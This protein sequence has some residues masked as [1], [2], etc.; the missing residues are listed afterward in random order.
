MEDKIS[1]IKRLSEKIVNRLGGRVIA[2]LSASMLLALLSV[3]FTDAWVVSIEQQGR[4]IDQIEKNVVALEQLRSSLISA[5]SAQRGFLLSRRDDFSEAFTHAVDDARRN[6]KKIEGL[7]TSKTLVMEGKQEQSWLIALNSSLEAKAAEMRLSLSFFKSGKEDEAR[8]LVNLDQGILDMAKFMQYTQLLLDQQNEALVTLIAKRRTTTAVTRAAIIGSAVIL[9]LLVIMVI[10]QLV[11]EM[12]NR[13]LLRQQ[14]IRDCDVYEERLQSS[15]RMLKTMALD[16][17]AD[18]ERDRQKL[19]RELHDELG[20]ILTATKMDISWTMRKLK[21]TDPDI[22]EKLGK[23]MRYLD[24]GIQFKRQVV[25]NLH[26]SMITTFGF[27][28][29]LRSLIDDMGERNQWEMD[30]ILP[31]DTTE[32]NEPVNLIAYR[33][34]QETLNNASK[35]AQATKVS[36][37]MVVALD[38]LKLEI[39]DNGV[40]MTMDIEQETTHGL[41]GMRNRIMA[42]GGRIEL[43]SQPGKGVHLLAIVPMQVDVA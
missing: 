11:H 14:L 39:E 1:W 35:Y 8:H 16:Y 12:T 32:L 22:T 6:I 19:A 26:P 42:I 40:G 10:R 7:V 4:Q 30:V 27:W 24:Q 21:T 5:E 3:V 18:V 20:S 31:D 15:T 29:A 2:V 38:Y 41:A 13:D 17:Q 36:V 28:P 25:Q 33:V 23:T 37:Q 9:L 43:S 34:V